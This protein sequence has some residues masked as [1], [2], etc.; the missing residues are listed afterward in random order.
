MEALTPPERAVLVLHE[1][2]DM[3]H[4]EVADIL[5]ISPR[6]VHKHLQRIYQK[7]GVETRTAAVVRAMQLRGAPRAPRE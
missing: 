6:T 5:G 3:S 7:L 4:A 1:A 2:F